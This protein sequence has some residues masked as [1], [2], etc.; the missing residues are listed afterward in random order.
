[1]IFRFDPIEM[2]APSTFRST[3]CPRT[4]HGFIEQ[5]SGS[6]MAL[7]RYCDCC[8]TCT[9]FSRFDLFI[10]DFILFFHVSAKSKEPF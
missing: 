10:E 1:M 5:S 9:Y 8:R 7:N 4:S 6:S 2:N 3:D